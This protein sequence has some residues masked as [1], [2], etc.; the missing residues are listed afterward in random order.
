M[1]FATQS[2]FDHERVFSAC[3]ATLPVYLFEVREFLFCE[4]F[5]VEKYGILGSMLI[6]PPFAFMDRGYL[7]KSL[8]RLDFF[9]IMVLY[10]SADLTFGHL[11]LCA[12][13]RKCG[14]G[15][16]VRVGV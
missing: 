8:L 4:G 14:G 12:S 15:T 7:A 11:S 16:S 9:L 6:D 10:S 1:P 5:G 3:I 2:S 13:L